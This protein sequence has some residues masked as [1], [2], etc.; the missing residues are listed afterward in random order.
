MLAATMP[1]E[2]GR[3][4]GAYEILGHLGTGGMGEVY[5]A[6]DT[7][8]GRIVAIKFISGDLHLERSA[9]ER[10]AREAQLA[11]SLNHPGI[12]TVYDVGESDDRPYI[13]MELID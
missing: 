11:S 1:L 10:L 5:R 12:V 2:L 7:R 8:L 6:R 3:R 9:R 13:V 4:I